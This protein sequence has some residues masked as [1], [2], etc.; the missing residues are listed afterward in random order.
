MNS[1]VSFWV[2]FANVV[3]VRPMDELM[4]V[5]TIITRSA[6]VVAFQDEIKQFVSFLLQDSS[7]SDCH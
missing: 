2:I 3:R 1:F 4:D 6:S 5:P 7:L